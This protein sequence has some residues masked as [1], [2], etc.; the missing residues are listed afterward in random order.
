MNINDFKVGQTAYILGFSIGG[1][2]KITECTVKTVGRQYVTVARD[3]ICTGKFA[4][5]ECCDNALTEASKFSYGNLLFSS[6][7][8]IQKYRELKELRR[9]FS[10]EATKANSY[11]LRQ[12]R[13]VKEILE[14]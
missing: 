9:W 10:A 2:E 7:E 3:N 5:N 11:S 14:G 13:K 4:N 12:L 6:K 8:E 1:A